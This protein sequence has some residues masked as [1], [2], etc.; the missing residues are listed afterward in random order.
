MTTEK[1]EKTGQIVGMEMGIV[2]NYTVSGAEIGGGDFKTDEQ[3][4]RFRSAMEIHM[5][6]DAFY[7]DMARELICSFLRIRFRD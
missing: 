7:A 4:D 5:D 2:E 1:T 3:K 6:S